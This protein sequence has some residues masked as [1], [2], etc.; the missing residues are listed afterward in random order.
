MIEVPDEGSTT[1]GRGDAANIRIADGT[2]S[3]VHCSIEI[4]GGVAMLK[5]AGSKTGTRVDGKSIKEHELRTDNIISI[6]TTKMRF[7]MSAPAKEEPNVLGLEPETAPGPEAEPWKP[8]PEER[9]KPGA[10]K[11]AAEPEPHKIETI[12]L[13][14][15]EIESLRK[16]GSLRPSNSTFKSEPPP[17]PQAKQQPMKE[18]PEEAAEGIEELRK[19]AG[20]KMAH[21]QIGPV[22]GIGSS[23]LVFKAKD[24]KD[25]REVA[26]KVYTP[27]FA[28]DEESKNRFVRAARTMMPMRHSN[29]VT[30]YGAGK[31]GPYCW[32]AMDYV[33]GEN[34]KET[35][36]RIGTKG[37]LDWRPALRMSLDIGRGLYYIHG[38]NII[39][40]SLSPG[41]L[42]VSKVGTVKLGSLILAKA[43]S[44]ALSKDVTVS[45][46]FLGE[47]SYLS[48][49]QVGAGGAVDQRADIYSFGA[50][51]YALLTSK[52]PHVGKNPLETATWIIRRELVSPRKA[53]PNIPPALEKIVVKMLQKNPEAR[54]QTAGELLAELE[55][56]PLA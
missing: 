23:G 54:F 5:D 33:E 11:S 38:E 12:G 43:L 35:I 15:Q 20:T 39:H 42:L 19:L 7:V 34:L 4:Y 50:L 32:M 10:K 56:L 27:E 52:P 21:Y 8:A 48:P 49:E 29:L 53:D 40:R 28:E 37:K 16:P 18:E 45:G 55:S 36:A 9:F 14:D 2:V 44:G 31:T 3:R 30:L 17:A 6:G 26:L 22:V 24:T 1:L 25:D 46:N 51:M 13:V 41:N 47:V